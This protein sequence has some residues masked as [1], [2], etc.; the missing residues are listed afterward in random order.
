[1]A[2]QLQLHK[3]DFSVTDILHENPELSTMDNLVRRSHVVITLDG[4]GPFTVFAPDNEAFEKLP[5][6]AIGGLIRTP[7]KLK[8]L[9]LYHVVPGTG[10]MRAQLDEEEL[11]PT[12]HVD[13]VSLIH[14]DDDT[15]VG[16]ARLGDAYNA[17]NGV[18]HIID[19]VLFP[20]F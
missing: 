17:D 3:P 13:P 14:A 5:D 11:L 7:W 4:D 10:M 6:G 9:L 15:Y 18:V 12:L 1:M 19:T 16:S 20:D 8:D 2:K